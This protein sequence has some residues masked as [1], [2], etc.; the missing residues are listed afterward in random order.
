MTASTSVRPE[1]TIDLS[2]A[3]VNHDPFPYYEEIRNLGPA[4]WNPASDSW[5]V[6]SFDLAKSVFSN[7]RDF[8]QKQDMYQEMYGT[9]ALPGQ[10]NPRHNE[11]RAIIAPLMSRKAAEGH[12]E[13]A[14]QIIHHHLG[15][16]FERMRDGETVD[17]A[18]IYRTVS[19][20]FMARL[21]GV[22]TEDC[23][24]FV[25][26]AEEMAGTFDLA[27]TPGR[28]DAEAIRQAATKATN[29]LNDYALQ[30]IN[31]RRGSGE[32]AD[33][34]SALANTDAELTDIEGVGYVTMLIQGGQDTV[35]T[36]AKNTTTAFA[37]HPDQRKALAED[38]GLM[39][40]ALDEV[41]RWQ[42]PVTAEVR[43]VRNAG[44]DI[45]GVPLQ[46]GDGVVL[47]LAAAHRDPSRWED[48]D[49]FDI[50]R[51]QMGNLGFGFGVHNCLGVNFAR[52]LV[53]S[54]TNT[55]LDEVPDFKVAIPL[56][57][58][59]YGQSYAIRGAQ[60]LPLTL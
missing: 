38:R 52:R 9:I 44:V 12:A 59:D 27:V 3:T 21:L 53:T 35:A 30:A 18:G 54:M 15:P 6:S 19:T 46:K 60:S 7:F 50:H 14:R 33:L 55:F 57:E 23:G 58:L 48:A 10:D 20:E 37:Q 47:L 8:A 2:D 17:V 51:P 39:Q 11:L 24:Q 25:T 13:L 22:P 40:Q 34:L 31:Q 41:I 26:W 28:E 42:A 45:G 4:V 32:N 1:S 36:W 56:D 5:L 16:V 49:V 29:E 43:V